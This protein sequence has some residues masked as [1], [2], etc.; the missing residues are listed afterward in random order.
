MTDEPTRIT[1]T[2]EYT[3]EELARADDPETALREAL[4]QS[5][6]DVYSIFPSSEKPEGGAGLDRACTSE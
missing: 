2:I 3:A 1:T 4:Q 5:L 6:Q